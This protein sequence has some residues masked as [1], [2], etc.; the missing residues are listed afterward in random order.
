[1]VHANSI[2]KEISGSNS[3]VSLVGN[4]SVS[5]DRIANSTNSTPSCSRTSSHENTLDSRSRESTLRESRDKSRES[6]LHRNARRN[7]R[8]IVEESRDRDNVKNQVVVPPPSYALVSA[9]VFKT[10]FSSWYALFYQFY[11]LPAI[12]NPTSQC[13]PCWRLRWPRW[14]LET[15]NQ[16]L[17]L[18]LF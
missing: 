2:P 14:H 10:I 6:T 15:I 7:S 9:R 17:F 3:T 11:V 8:E 12:E 1:M 18:T 16:G 4:R 5:S 13:F